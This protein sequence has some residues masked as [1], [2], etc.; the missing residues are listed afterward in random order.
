MTTQQ[1]SMTENDLLQ[2]P[3]IDGLVR[4]IKQ[5]ETVS[6]APKETPEPVA[7]DSWAA[8]L[9]CSRQYEY[10]KKKGNRKT[11]LID[12]EI[13]ETLKVCDINKM[14]TATLVN[15]ILRAFIYQNQDILRQYITQRNTL[16]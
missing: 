11:C 12:E 4:N 1:T 6:T 13:I 9:S 14:S 16:L 7:T 3:E 15:S 10:R 8:F 2:L 5:Q